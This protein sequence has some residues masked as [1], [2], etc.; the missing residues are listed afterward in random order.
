MIN[1]K[2]SIQCDEESTPSSSATPLSKARRKGSTE[3]PVQ[4]VCLCCGHNIVSSTRT[5][6]GK[7]NTSNVLTSKFMNFMKEWVKENPLK[8]AQ[9][10]KRKNQAF[11]KDP[12]YCHDRGC[13]Y[14]QWISRF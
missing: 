2:L 10:E 14:D 12:V 3:K 4:L 13:I 9:M 11:L 7:L 5:H 1:T 8:N 6:I